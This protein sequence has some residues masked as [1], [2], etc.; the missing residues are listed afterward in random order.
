MANTSW[1]DI[2]GSG[3]YT[4]WDDWSDAKAG[5]FVTATAGERGESTAE[6]HDVGTNF[7]LAGATT[8]STYRWELSCVSGGE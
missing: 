2:G 4:A 1:I 7:N 8:N 5:D 6:F 3:H